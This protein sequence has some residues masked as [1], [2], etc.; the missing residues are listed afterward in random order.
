MT[1]VV[2]ITGGFGYLG[3]RIAQQLAKTK[4]TTVR[5]ATRRHDSSAPAW[6]PEAEVVTL[7]LD[8]DPSIETA[9]K[10]VHA[11]IH[12][13]ALDAKEC[14]DDPQCALQVNGAGFRRH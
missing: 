12:L 2:L 5:L 14:G 1:N 8:N 9:C 7:A 4:G 11:V 10:G 13:A 3:G 6:L